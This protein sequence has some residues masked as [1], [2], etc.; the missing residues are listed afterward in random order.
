MTKIKCDCGHVNP[1]G[2]FLCESCGKPLQKQ[3]EKLLDMRYDGS[4]R[5]SQ[6]YQKTLI[7]KIWNFFS[8]VKVGVWLII[9]TLSAS[10]FGTILPQEMYL[11]PDAQA[12]TYY[13]KQYGLIGQIYYILGFHNLY[14]SWWFIILIALLGVS[15]VICSLDRVIPL[16]RA[17]KNQG[18]TRNTSFMKRQRLYSLTETELSEEKRIQIIETLKKRRYR[19]KEEN[20]NLF[21]EKGRFSRWGPYVN[22]IGLIVFLIGVMLR[23]VPGMYVDETLWIREGETVPIPGTEGHYY[24]KNDRFI[25]EMYNSKQEKEVF[26]DAITKAGD[27]MVAKNYQTDVA[28]YER[29]NKSLPGESPKLKKLRNGTIK[30]NEPLK[31]SSYSLYQ[32]TYKE[33]E[34]DKMVF[35]LIAKNTGKSFGSVS[36]DLLEP[37]SNYDLGNGYKVH[38]ASYLP[39]FYFNKDGEPSTKT[40]NPNNPAFVFQIITPDKPNG[41]KSFVAIQETIEGSANNKYKMKFDHVETKNISGLTVRKDLTLWVLMIGGVIFMIGVIQGMY[42]QHRRIWL[43]SEDDQV[44]VA[45]HTNKNWYGL[46]KDLQKVLMDTGISEP[47]DQKELLKEN[48]SA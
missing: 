9:I 4:A 46:K 37:K 10:A 17:L 44:L 18:I 8:S 19:V 24:L 25:K 6:T 39:D 11:P 32:T 21:A 48:R 1:L 45:G 7:D 43:R 20:K 33:G 41:E 36:I 16:H 42:W 5:R 22:H 28:L 14:G 12:D 23:Y 31:F 35:K 40:K 13:Q 15:L 30:V 26:S 2:T 3:D 47:T 34:L 29:K 27:G 38:L